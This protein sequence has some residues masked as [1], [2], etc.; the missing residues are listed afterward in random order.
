MGGGRD[1]RVCVCVCVCVFVHVCV[2]VCLSVCLQVFL[3]QFLS[4]SLYISLSLFPSFLSLFLTFP[5]SPPPTYNCSICTAY[6]LWQPPHFTCTSCCVATHRP[7]TRD[8]RRFPLLSCSP[9][10]SLLSSDYPLL[11]ILCR[12]EQ[13]VDERCSRASIRILAHTLLHWILETDFRT[14]A[15]GSLPVMLK[16]CIGNFSSFSSTDF[17]SSDIV[18]LRYAWGGKECHRVRGLCTWKSSVKMT[19]AFSREEHVNRR[20]SMCVQTQ[21]VHVC[22]HVRMNVNLFVCLIYARMHVGHAGKHPC[23]H[24]H[25]N[26]KI[27]GNMQ[28]YHEWCIRTRDNVVYWKTNRK[29]IND[30]QYVRNLT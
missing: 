5:V 21:C 29:I 11:N 19:R 18:D 16:P 1:N 14:T 15:S 22:M 9:F 23:I 10:L 3:F 17:S 12:N 20:A 27:G 4:L 24:T 7:W 8:N 25:I 26:T 28:N 13:V 30:L 6:C 2:C